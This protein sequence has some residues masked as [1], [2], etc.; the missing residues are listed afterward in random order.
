MKLSVL[1]SQGPSLRVRKAYVLNQRKKSVPNLLQVIYG[2][3]LG[4]PYLG[5][6]LESAL[7]AVPVFFL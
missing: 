3:E 5:Q 6:G 4:F 7:T 1:V 2:L